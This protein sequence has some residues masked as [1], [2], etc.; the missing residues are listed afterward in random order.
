MPESAESYAKD[1]VAK[2]NV[3]VCE[4]FIVKRVKMNKIRV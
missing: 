4:I 3:A 2:T 1:L